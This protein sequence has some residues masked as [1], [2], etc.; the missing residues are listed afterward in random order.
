MFD[1]KYIIPRN[2]LTHPAW[3]LYKDEADAIGKTG[4]GQ[5]KDLNK[6]Y[7]PWSDPTH[8]N[9]NAYSIFV[10]ES[11]QDPFVKYWTLGPGLLPI[12]DQRV[13]YFYRENDAWRAYQ[14]MVENRYVFTKGVPWAFE[15][16]VPR[17]D[18]L[19]A[20]FG[21]SGENGVSYGYPLKLNVAN[22]SVVLLPPYVS[23]KPEVVGIPYQKFIQGLPKVV[24]EDKIQV[25]VGICNNSAFTYEDKIAAIIKVVTSPDTVPDPVLTGEVSKKE[26]FS[27]SPLTPKG[28]AATKEDRENA[29]IGAVGANFSDEVAKKYEAALINLPELEKAYKDAWVDRPE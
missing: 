16:Y 25:I 11:N 1:D 8:T 14:A 20:N 13:K 5:T 19:E 22:E 26:V 23:G 10:G 2:K 9:S 4:V 29:A 6:P 12:D 24:K 15:I 27:K 21:N 17:K 7:K 3:V 18:T 28:L